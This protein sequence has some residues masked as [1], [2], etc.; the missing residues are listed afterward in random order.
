MKV[1][2]TWKR[3][4]ATV[5]G[6]AALAATS[7][8]QQVRIEQPDL[9]VRSSGVRVSPPQPAAGA[10]VDIAVRVANVGAAATRARVVCELLANDRVEDRVAARKELAVG[11]RPRA[12]EVIRWRVKMPPGR[13]VRLVVEARV[14]GGPDDADPTN[15]RT[16]VP[17][18]PEPRTVDEGS[19]TVTPPSLA[20]LTITR[21]DVLVH[22]GRPLPGDEVMVTAV[23]RNVG[24]ADAAEAWAHFYL[25]VDGTLTT[26][27]SVTDAV[28]T[29]GTTGFVWRF[30]MP[31]ARQV[32]LSVTTGAPNDGNNTNGW[33]ELWIRR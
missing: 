5:C 20:D 10:H 30:R 14:E 27:G 11:I 23:V 8:A 25:Y 17:L 15:N 24:R 18:S 26:R 13:N 29:S 22:P 31:R 19:V 16:V 9:L 6:A 21:D 4:A 12:A 3:L 32:L 1:H 33:A 28:R 7:T 2:G